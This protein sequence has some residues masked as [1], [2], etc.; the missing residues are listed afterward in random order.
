M[1]IRAAIDRILQL[2]DL[3]GAQA[4]T[5][6]DTVPCG[7]ARTANDSS[8]E[9]GTN[10]QDS[11][12]DTE[13]LQR[14][15]NNNT[16]EGMASRNFRD[17]PLCAQSNQFSPLPRSSPFT[18]DS[19]FMDVDR[20]MILE[21]ESSPRPPP[22]PITEWSNEQSMM[23][24]HYFPATQ[25]MHPSKDSGHGQTWGT[26]SPYLFSGSKIH[27][28][29]ELSLS[30][31]SH[32]PTFR[33][34]EFSDS[35]DRVRC[36]H[37][38]QP[39]KDNSDIVPMTHLPLDFLSDPDPWATIGRILQVERLKETA[40]GSNQTA[41]RFGSVHKPLEDALAHDLNTFDDDVKLSSRLRSGLPIWKK[42][43]H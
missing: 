41:S 26:F 17:R 31:L 21:F 15:E 9:Y 16:D 10:D 20:D 36:I 1:S 29:P 23:F 32:Q 14:P 43:G 40:V 19:S 35:P 33:G 13:H 7:G 5:H 24:G 42:M 30:F 11:P 25:H 3:V 18:T 8:D 28:S 37:E 34:L 6:K 12:F 27:S 22:S 39:V 38:T 4:V 2:P